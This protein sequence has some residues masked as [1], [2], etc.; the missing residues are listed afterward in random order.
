MYHPSLSLLAPSLS[1]NQEKRIESGV[2]KRRRGMVM[3]WKRVCVTMIK[4]MGG[5]KGERN[6]TTNTV[7]LGIKNSPVW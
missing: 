1:Q 7:R 2:K 3:R 4:F 5:R 6:S